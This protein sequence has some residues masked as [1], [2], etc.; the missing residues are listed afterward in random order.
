M[1]VIDTDRVMRDAT[2]KVW[3]CL[4]VVAQ[5]TV[6]AVHLA[7]SSP[8]CLS[9]VISGLPSFR[10]RF[11]GGYGLFCKKRGMVTLP[12]SSSLFLCCITIDE[13]ANCP[14]ACAQ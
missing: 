13:I 9:L 2:G 14:P 8:T 7:I 11:S 12:C 6:H 5:V 3:I 10:E 4:D 1:D